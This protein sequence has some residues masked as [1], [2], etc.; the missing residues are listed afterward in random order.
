MDI[1]LPNGKE[2]RSP[3]SIP[4]SHLQKERFLYLTDTSDKRV[5]SLTEEVLMSAL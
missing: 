2:S 1:F 4:N 3:L 5:K